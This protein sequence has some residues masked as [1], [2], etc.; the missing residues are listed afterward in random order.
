MYATVFESP[1]QATF[2]TGTKAKILQ[3]T[4]S[5][6]DRMLISMLSSVMHQ[7]IHEVGQSITDLWETDKSREQCGLWE[8]PETDF[9][10]KDKRLSQWAIKHLMKVNQNKCGLI[11][12][13]PGHHL[14]K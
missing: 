12:L 13:L 10:Q 3:S 14:K 1:D 2:T 8:R 4:P 5:T 9:G 11:S 6:R 7:N